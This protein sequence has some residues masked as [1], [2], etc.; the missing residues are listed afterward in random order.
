MGHNH[1]S[2][3]ALS[4]EPTLVEHDHSQHM[5][6]ADGA[7]AHDHVGHMMSMAVSAAAAAASGKPVSGC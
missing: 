4:S 7:M 5:A 3:M 6:A 2:M 1:D